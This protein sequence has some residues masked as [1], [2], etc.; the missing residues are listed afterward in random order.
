MIVY[1]T[2]VAKSEF[3]KPSIHIYNKIEKSALNK[4]QRMYLLLNTRIKKIVL[5]NR[6]K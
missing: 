4:E 6:T 5:T 2:V 3:Y 1:V